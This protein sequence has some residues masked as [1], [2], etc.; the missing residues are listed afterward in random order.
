MKADPAIFKGK[1]VAVYLRR[2]KGESGTTKDQWEAVEPSIDFLIGKRIIKKFNKGVK[3]RDIDKKRT[4]IDLSI[5]G[6]I[7]NEGEGASGYNVAERKVFMALMKELRAGNYDAVIALDF[8]RL[9]RNYGALSRY[10]YDL[11]GERVPATLF[12]GLTENMGLGQ[13]GQQGI[14]NEKVLSS[15][16]EW[17]G[18]AKSLEIQKGEKKRV[19][20][21]VERGYLL[22]SRPEWLGKTYRG[23]TSKGVKYRDAWLAIAEGKSSGG[24][25]RAAGKFS[26]DGSPDGGFVRNWKNRLINYHE[27]GVLEGWVDA[28]E[29]VN[30][31]ITDLGGYPK[32]AIKTTAV[33]NILKAT[34]G[35]FA[36]PG[37]VLLIDPESKQVEFVEFPYPLDI[38]LDSLASTDDARELEDFIVFRSEPESTK[39]YNPFQ[40]QPRS[41][42]V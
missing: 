18:L 25:A 33:K 6:D 12:W 41:A 21:N 17:G 30:Q 31:Y 1:K 5:P 16:M 4:G 40:T 37:G 23:K 11:W 26:K 32:V 20:G 8:S 28:V 42:N 35:Y 14:I 15:L 34:A 13:P 9:G 3:G 36:Y 24:I 7:W 27:M 2:S 19:S 39:D 29:A 10:A 22:G 38:G